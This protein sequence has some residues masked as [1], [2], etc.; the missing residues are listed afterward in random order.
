MQ[1]LPLDEQVIRD[2]VDAVF[3][4]RVFNSTS[5]FE[6]FWSWLLDRLG[7]LFSL[8]DPLWDEVRGSPPVTWLL[9]GLLAV[10]LVLV[11]AQAFRT[12]SRG[13]ES[14]RAGFGW[15]DAA[16]RRRGDPW[17]MALSESARGNYTEAAH[18]LYQALLEAAARREEVRLHPSK[19]VGDYVRELR[20]RSSALFGRF[21]EFARSYETVIYGIGYCDRERYERL[22]SLAMPI[23][24]PDG[25]A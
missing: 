22:L 18:A 15:G 12:W 11:L 1:S 7:R 21:R 2:T 25:A 23:V 9:I 3:S 5:L 8:L 16:L 4:G 14:R 10:L 13:R 17:Q 6:R 19:T 20:A 24:R